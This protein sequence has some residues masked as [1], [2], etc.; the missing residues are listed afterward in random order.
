MIILN[1]MTLWLESVMIVKK[2]KEK[3]EYLGQRKFGH[4]S[5]S[6]NVGEKYN[7]VLIKMPFIIFWH[8]LFFCSFL[9][10]W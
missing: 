1:F 7:V 9:E 6:D 4:S 5:M 3:E 8:F 2:K 10:L